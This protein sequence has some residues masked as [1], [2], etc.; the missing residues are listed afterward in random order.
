MAFY[1]SW[2]NSQRSEQLILSCLSPA[3]GLPR[4]RGA[5]PSACLQEQLHGRVT[6]VL[7]G[8]FDGGPGLL[9]ASCC[10]QRARST[11]AGAGRTPVPPLRA[12]PATGP[13]RAGEAGPVV[14]DTA[15]RSGRRSGRPRPGPHIAR[16]R[17]AFIFSRLFGL[18]NRKS[19]LFFK[20]TS[21]AWG[22]ANISSV[23]PLILLVFCHVDFFMQL[24]FIFHGFSVGCFFPTQRLYQKVLP[25]FL[26]VPLWVSPLCFNH[27]S[28][29]LF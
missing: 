27:R 3:L 28:A 5:W 22:L 26:P 2:V 15:P 21:S 12:L 20:K 29:H 4:R 25:C 24:D 13:P 8:G 19:S 9:L 11:R 1:R 23:R 10:S 7:G 14:R 17:P 6:F 16:A 18:L